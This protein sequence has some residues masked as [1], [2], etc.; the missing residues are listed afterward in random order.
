[1]SF[2]SCKKSVPLGYRRFG[3]TNTVWGQCSHVYHMHCLLEWLGTPT[4]KQSC[5]IL[6]F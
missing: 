6:R 5:P 4:S 3:T 2:S 1:M